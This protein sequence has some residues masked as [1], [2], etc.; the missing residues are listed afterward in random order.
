MDD[1]VRK[2][3]L[4]LAEDCGWPL[5]ED[6]I[7]RSAWPV[8]NAALGL[9]DEVA[10]DSVEIYELRPLTT[11]QPWGVFFLAVKGTS[12]LS[13]TLLRKLL[14]G[15]VKKKRASA[16]TSNLQQWNLED[17]MFVCSLDEPENTTRYFA[18]FKEQEKGLPKLMIGAR[19]ED[20]QPEN[21]IKAAKLKLK[22]NLKWPDNETDIDSWREKWAKAFPIGHKEVIKTSSN[23]AKALAKYA[24][25]ID[26]QIPK[27]YEIEHENGPLHKL[28][29]AFKQSLLKGLSLKDFSDMIAQTV[30][31][32]LFSSRATGAELISLLTLEEC[33]PSSPFLSD[34]FSEFVR[35]SAGDNHES[36]DFDE[37]GIDELIEMLNGSN[38]QGIMEEFGNQFKSGKEDPVIHFYEEFLKSYNSKKK[39]E[40]GVFYTPSPVVSYIVNSIDTLLKQKYNLEYG[41]ADTSTWEQVVAENASINIPHNVSKTDCFVKILDPATGTGT[42]IVEVIKRIY[43]NLEF[44]WAKEGHLK[45]KHPILW[46]EYVNDFLLDRIYGYELLMAPYTICHMKIMLTLAQLGLATFPERRLNVFLT[47]SLERPSQLSNWIPDFLALENKQVNAVKNDT[48]FTIVL[49]NPPYSVHSANKSNYV[50]DL[51]KSD[52]YPDDEIKEQN[53]KLLLDDYVKFIRY[54][55]SVIGKT[56]CGIRGV[57]VNHGYVNNPTFR[58]FRQQQIHMWDEIYSLDLHGNSSKKEKTPTGG[59]DENVFEIKQGVSI[60]ICLVSSSGASSKTSVNVSDLWGIRKHKYTELIEK[61]TANFD[62]NSI[63]PKSPFFLFKRTN[64]ENLAPYE[65]FIPLNKIFPKFSA[66]IKT[67][68]D[69]FAIDFTRE[70]IESRID[71]F[72][73]KEIMDDELRVKYNLKDTRDWKLREKRSSISSNPNWQENFGIIHYRP[74]DFRHCYHHSD[75]VELPRQDTMKLLDSGSSLSLISARTNKSNEMDHFLISKYKSEAKCGENSTQ[76]SVFVIFDNDG[77]FKVDQKLFRAVNNIIDTNPR[78]FLHYIYAIYHSKNYREL[79]KEILAIDYPRIPITNDREIYQQVSR[80][81]ADLV[82]LHLFDD[83]YSYASWNID[84]K[85]KVFESLEC[86]FVEGKNNRIVGSVKASDVYQN[87]DVYTDTKDI[88]NCSKFS[89]VPQEVWEYKIGGYQVCQ[90]WLYDRRKIGDKIGQYLTDGDILH[91]RKIVT[92][93]QETI[94]IQRKLD[95]Y[96]DKKGGWP[97]KGSADFIMP[98]DNIHVNQKTL[99]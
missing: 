67:H 21:E 28:H 29:E 63:E 96:I 33:A 60:L 7:D 65:A 36:L 22:S 27:I 90:K 10:V 14:R 24:T 94:T 8:N 42:F 53:P 70:V 64:Q 79:Y 59:K 31:Y 92:S 98:D 51:V 84:E 80:Y 75:V 43:H 91:Y 2:L 93:I 72:R 55:D 19:W 69:H 50:T 3:I 54:M 17:L 78:E 83:E 46:E 45:S 95:E 57:I 40:R 5:D 58:K 49:G 4:F 1:D 32:G 44:K 26:Q 86:I 39:V 66:G 13:V 47:N 12:K 52:Y 38:I 82:A 9:N 71:D 88:E 61:T 25:R 15:L 18:H 87:G 41:L 68:R 6:Q 30:T 56:N 23:L 34:L 20:S 81:G 74:F 48:A 76:S 62:W 16:D 77:N 11:N 37:F 35:L 89:N 73:N 99:F 97:I 85:K